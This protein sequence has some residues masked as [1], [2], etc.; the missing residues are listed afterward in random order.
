MIDMLIDVYYDHRHTDK[1]KQTLNHRHDVLTCTRA[2]MI[3]T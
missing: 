2:H 1:R 3:T